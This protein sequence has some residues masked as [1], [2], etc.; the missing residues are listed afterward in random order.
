VEHFDVAIIG[1]GPGGLKCAELL[2]GSDFKT[3]L[4]EKSETIG[5]K[6]CAGGVT[7]NLG[8]PDYLLQKTNSF[9]R[10][11]VILNWKEYIFDMDDPLMIIDRTVL[12]KFQFELLKDYKNIKVKT[13]IEVT[14][15][16]NNGGNLF[17]PEE[18]AKS[19]KYIVTSDGEK[20]S[21]NFLVGA[22]GSQSITRKFLG[23]ENKIHIGAH[24][25]IPVVFDK[26]V[27]FLNP[28]KL[29]TG[30]CW[31]FP[32]NEFTSCGVYYDPEVVSFSE[33]KNVLDDMLEEFGLNYSGVEFRGFPVNCLYNGLKFGNVYL[34][35]DAAGVV[36]PVTGEGISTALESGAYA[37]RDI[38]QEPEALARLESIL[39]HR[40][41]QS[42]YLNVINLIGNHHIQS[43]LF[44]LFIYAIKRS[45]TGRGK[46]D[47]KTH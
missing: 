47:T 31:I 16:V 15:I 13:G 45:L 10:Q 33:S 1:A 25:K 39:K 6:I 30:Y 40:K 37:A 4:I 34:C 9:T 38:L 14:R 21:F 11:H 41:R 19:K 29:G 46:D 20:I 42:R 23:L 36:F 28:E 26:V 27:W 44:R 17:T 22:D 35:G 3:V 24:Y 2:G 32:H 18:N 43:L 12:G 5:P 8:L 7:S